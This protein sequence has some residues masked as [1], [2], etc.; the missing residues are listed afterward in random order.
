LVYEIP[1]MVR[2]SFERRRNLLFG[3]ALS[4]AL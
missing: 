2:V 3:Y 4:I 1:G